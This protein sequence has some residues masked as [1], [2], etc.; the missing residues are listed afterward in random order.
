[1]TGW[2]WPSPSVSPLPTAPSWPFP[3]WHACIARAQDSCPKLAR[4]MIEEILGWWP[5]RRITLIGDGGYAAKELL[6]DI[7]V[8]V[9]FVGR[10]KGNAALYDPQVPVSTTKR[11]GPKPKKGP[12]LNSH[13][14]AAAR[15][16]RKRC[17]E[18][19]G[20][21]RKVPVCAYGKERQLQ[22]L[23]Y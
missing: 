18:G 17:Q 11:R 7:D 5:D 2:S 16:D 19:A 4:Q 21:W 9:A 22:V 20:V 23:T 13:Q 10:L 6:K 8:R 12:H 1:T 14:Q 15:A 3:C